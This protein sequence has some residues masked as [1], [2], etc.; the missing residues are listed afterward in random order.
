MYVQHW[1]R[2]HTLVY[3]Q[4]SFAY[5]MLPSAKGV[6]A[7]HCAIEIILRGFCT[8]QFI[9]HHSSLEYVR[10]VY[11]FLTQRKIGNAAVKENRLRINEEKEETHYLSIKMMRG[12]KLQCRIWAI[13]N[14]CI[15][16]NAHCIC[17]ASTCNV[18]IPHRQFATTSLWQCNATVLTADGAVIVPQL[19]SYLIATSG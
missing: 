14:T 15:Q 3:E 2:I 10:R 1:K 13:K 8:S 4:N 18:S 6:L 9:A 7:H 11:S 16:R 19:L 17:S 12:F 5:K